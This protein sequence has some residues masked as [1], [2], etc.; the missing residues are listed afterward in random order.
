[1]DNA[2]SND[3]AI[4]VLKKRINNMNGLVLDGV[5]AL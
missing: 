2:S 1:M 3:V 4:G 5:F